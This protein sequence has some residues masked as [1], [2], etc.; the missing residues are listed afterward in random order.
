MMIKIRD[1]IKIRRL[2][3]KTFLKFVA[4]GIVN[5]VFG[6][7]I[8]FVCYNFFYLNYWM[9][10]FA[11]YFFGSILSYFLNK[12]FTFQDK[13]KT[14]STIV[15]FVVNIVVC[16]LLAYGMAKPMIRMLFASFGKNLQENIAMLTGAVFFIIINYIGQRF[17]VFV[18]KD[19][20]KISDNSGHFI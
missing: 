8:M 18:K 19:K 6:T 13:R 9:S 20:G 12:Y 4:V 1:K 16:Y 11:N 2:V 7:G 5:T 14:S 15:K 17:F 3:D 10:S